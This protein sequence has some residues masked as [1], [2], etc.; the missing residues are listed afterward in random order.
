MNGELPPDARVLVVLMGS[1]GDVTRGLGVVRPLRA[2]LP[3]GRLGWLVEPVAEPLVRLLPEIDEVFVFDRPRGVGAVPALRRDLKRFGPSTTLDLQ[4]HFKSGFFSRLSG[5]PRRLGFHRRDAKEM[6]HLFQTETIEYVGDGV[7][8]SEH[9]DRFLRHLGVTASFDSTPFREAPVEIPTPLDRPYVAVVLGS[10]WATKDWPA[11]GYHRLLG[12]IVR[13]GR[14]GAVLVGDR[15]RRTLGDELVAAYPGAPI[16][17][18]AGA[19][20][21]PE[22]VGIMRGARAGVGPDSG[23]GH[24]AA[25]VGKRYVGIFGPTSPV[26]TAPA[27]S[28]GLAVLSSVG[29][30][31]CYRR[32]CPGLDT[33]CMRLV[34]PEA[35]WERLEGVLVG[36]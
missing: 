36:G 20:T 7:S 1:I 30:A 26:R 5:A 23:P 11:A 28:E 35:V 19:T 10:A 6:N 13:S 34:S 9:Y 25:A 15:K 3:T 14:F 16:V 32:R 12:S 24:I 31:P 33:V 29:C 27:G 8:K 2:A 17:N 22:L 21:L 18:L 4:R